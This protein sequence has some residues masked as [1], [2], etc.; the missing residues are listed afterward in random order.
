MPDPFNQH[1]QERKH[2]NRQNNHR[3]SLLHKFQASKEIPS[4][5][6]KQGPEQGSNNI[7]G[8][9]LFILHLSYARYKRRKG[10]HNRN[11]SCVDDRFPSVFIVKVLRFFEMFFFDSL[12][13]SA[14]D[15]W[16]E[17]FPDFVVDRIS[18]H[19]CEKNNNPNQMNTDAICRIPC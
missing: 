9:E 13:F 6:K 16:S 3:K 11:K 5:H 12:V 17:K 2:D 14:E 10:S 4:I 15:L 8:N 7:K 1:W 19:R 18:D